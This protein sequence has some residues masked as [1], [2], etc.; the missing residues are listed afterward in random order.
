MNKKEVL[1]SVKIIILGLMLSLSAIYA[2]SATNPPGD[3]VSGPLNEGS[4]KQSKAG[5]LDIT[6]GYLRVTSATGGFISAG[7]AQFSNGVLFSNPVGLITAINPI[8]AAY[9]QS[10]NGYSSQSSPDYTFWNDTDTGMFHPTPGNILGF[11]TAGGQRVRID[12][13]G[14][15]RITNLAHAPFSGT[16][17]SLVCA[18]AT[19]QLQIC[20]P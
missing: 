2:F 14:A 19:G 1:Q 18:T 16:T 9:I 7:M 12:G 13:A 5:D 6:A 17:E 3:N 15:F 20:T 10:K 8:S 4:A 11:S